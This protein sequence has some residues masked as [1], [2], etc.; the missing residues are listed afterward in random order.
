ALSETHHLGRLSDGAGSLLELETRLLDELG[1]AVF[2]LADPFT[3]LRR[4]HGQRRRALRA[5]LL[6][7]VG[8]GGDAV[9]FS[10]QLRDE[11]GWHLGGTEDSLPGSRHESFEAR[12]LAHRRYVG[13]VWIALLAG[14]SERAHFTAF[15]VRH[16]LQHAEEQH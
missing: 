12:R 16:G 11:I 4:S 6:L 8:K 2:L 9:H 3:E 5:E 13:I 14:D 7:D 10:I 15:H 1:P